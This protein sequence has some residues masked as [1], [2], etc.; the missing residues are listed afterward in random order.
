[1]EAEFKG[2]PISG[3]V[4]IADDDADFRRL[5]V[6]RATRM[7]LTVVEASSGTEALEA[8][9]TRSFDAVVVDVYMPGCSGVEVA[10]EARNLDSHVQAIVLTGSATLENAIEALRAGVYDYLTK[11]LESLDA[12]E[13][14]LSRALE[15]QRLLR[16][17]SRLFAEVQRLAVTDPLT[18]LYNRRK[19]TDA[20]EVEVERSRRYGRSLSI[21]MLDLDGLKRINDT[22][23]H[24]VGD[25]V[26]Q[27]AANAIRT[28]IRKVDLATR[29]GGD[30]F[31]L[32]LPEAELMD[33]AG[34]AGRIFE[35]FST[36][37]VHGEKVSACAGVTQWRQCYSTPAEFVG[38]ADQALY[39]AKRGGA[40]RIA[41]VFP[42]PEG[43]KG[44]CIEEW[45][46]QA[47]AT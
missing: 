19:L 26:L 10:Q 43:E 14:S 22:R 33:A 42:A 36:L 9:R 47:A 16:E 8:V 2:L 28:E 1:M 44:E 35:R 40:G 30:E 5:L 17:N 4:L 12:F 6:R 7:G 39:E 37:S 21:V 32:L 38:A 24:N 31:L 15:L 3:L 27:A 11:P 23:G 18:G 45:L 29:L 41:V 46:P 34:V 20:L 25:E 13:V